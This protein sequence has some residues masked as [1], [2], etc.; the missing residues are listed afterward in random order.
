MLGLV[1][2]H[3]ATESQ[4]VGAEMAKAGDFHVEEPSK[5][6]DSQAGRARGCVTQPLFDFKKRDILKI[7]EKP[8]EQWWN[9]DSKGK[10]ALIPVPYVEKY[11][12]A[13]ISGLAVIGGHSKGGW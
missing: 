7:Q 1:G 6:S 9:E 3:M 13:S 10:R 5:W 8:E 11:R 2:M 12:P 4:H